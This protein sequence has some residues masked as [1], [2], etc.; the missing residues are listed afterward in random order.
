MKKILFFAITSLFLYGCAT[1]SAFK[2]PIPIND[3][4]SEILAEDS[5]EYELLI[6]DIGFESWLATRSS[7]ATA[8]SN[9]YYKNWNHIYVTEWNQKHLQGHPYFEN[10][11]SYDPFEDYGF[12]INYKL[13]NYFLF[14]EE[15]TGISLVRR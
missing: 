14:V 10:Y 8:H 12:D 7:I 9:T 1:Q 4:N 11:I 15:K 6:L 13:Y 3:T 5:T 2:K